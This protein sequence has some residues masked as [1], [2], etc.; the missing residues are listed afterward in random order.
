VSLSEDNP[1]DLATAIQAGVRVP[2]A[3]VA[4]EGPSGSTGP[5]APPPTLP[6]A[7]PVGD[8]NDAGTAQPPDFVFAIGRIE[9]RFPNLE[10]E[11]EMA[12]AT[13][14]S[15]TAGLTDRQALQSILSDRSNRYLARQLA[16]VLTIEGLETYLLAP[17]DPVDLDLLIEAVRPTPH[18]TDVD[19]VIGIRGP[20][21]PPEAANGL[22]IPIVAFD[23]IF[24]FDQDELIGAIPRPD[25]ISEED[26][27]PTAQE[28]FGRLV[29]I[30][31]NAGATDEHRAL[32]FLAV[33]YAAIYARASEQFG[34][35]ASLV[36]VR[37]RPSRLSGVR[38]VLD[39]IFVFR[40]R[41]TDVEESYF[42]RVDVTGEFPFLV[43]RLTQY[44]ERQ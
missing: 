42:V 16:W 27:A 3:D 25:S 17:R 28:L 6:P 32:N 35:N 39:V 22:V 23:Q 10:V 2:Q 1:Y 40:H 33:R 26:F 31:D 41:E 34:Q 29:Q 8:G 36:A 4:T 20:L 12:Q 19:V 44:Y 37:V 43:T 21:A 30:A 18:P 11:K 24:S 5:S 14:R 7:Q 9:P 13:G 38:R 15:D